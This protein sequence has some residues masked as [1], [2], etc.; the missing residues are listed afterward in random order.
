MHGDIIH[1]GKHW[2][3]HQVIPWTKFGTHF[4]E[5][6]INMGT[7]SFRKVAFQNCICNM[8]TILSQLH[9]VNYMCPIFSYRLRV[10]PSRKNLFTGRMSLWWT[11]TQMVGF[12]LK[13]T[14]PSI[15][16]ALRRCSIAIIAPNQVWKRFLWNSAKH[17]RDHFVN[18]PSQCE[19]PS[20][21]NVV[22]HWL[23]ASTK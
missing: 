1:L 16:Y 11:W 2:C 21:C 20:H 18:A 10:C 6:L 13:S 15:Q 8:V 9:R 3:R 19:T 23:G 4:C 7:F 17:S 5:I 22:S 12:T 14:D